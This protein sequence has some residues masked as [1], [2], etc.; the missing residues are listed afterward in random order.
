MPASIL[1]K[2]LFAHN[3]FDKREKAIPKK[4]TFSFS[5]VMKFFLTPVLLMYFTALS[6]Q[7]QPYLLVGTY[8]GG[9]SKGI[10]VFRFGTNGKAMP[11][12]SISTPNPSFMAISPD[13]KTVYAVNE[14]GAPE[15]G[16][17]VSA[18]RFNGTSGRL[19]FLN[20]ESSEGEHPCYVTADKTGKWVIAG[21]YSSG[22]LAVLP[23]K[24]NGSLGKPVATIKHSGS[25]V[26][27][28]QEGPHVHQTVLS[29][30]NKT[31]F[32]PDLGIDKLMVYSFNDAKGS[33][34]PKDTS[35]SLPAGSGPRHLDLH[36]TG[37]WVY[38]LQELSG[39]ITVFKNR[40]GKLQ[41]ER[42]VSA[43]PA[44][45]NQPFSGADIHVS[46]DGRF[47]YASLR[48]ESNTLAIFRISPSTGRLTL[49]GHQSTHGK[50]PR[51]FNFDPS[52]NY[53][54]VGNQRSD[55]IVIFRVNKKTGQLTD[56]GNRIAVGS[57]VC[58]KWIRP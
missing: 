58:I 55:E 27:R 15:G 18:F 30:D 21:N 8:T 2:L 17:K 9:K 44:E 47:L 45:F 4:D 24:A 39:K 34:E 5:A 16:G 56:T 50:T 40:N 19:M 52:G 31:L 7:K 3:S 49:K 57:P 46:P 26:D 25:S 6:A 32:V 51:N 42:T 43:L 14:V 23:V 54:L 38:L 12:D 37:K 53:L 10:Y 11:V 13:Q 22:T 28:R 48:D 1:L 41:E 20:Q 35:I 36:P 33:L 29:P